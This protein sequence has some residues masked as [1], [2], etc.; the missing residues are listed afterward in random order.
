[1]TKNVIGDWYCSV[2]LRNFKR[3][4][5]AGLHLAQM[6][7]CREQHG[8]IFQNRGNQKDKTE[9]YKAVEKPLV[10]E[11]KEKLD[12]GSEDAIKIES[13]HR[14]QKKSV[15]ERKA[16]NNTQKRRSTRLGKRNWSPGYI[17]RV[18]DWCREQLSDEKA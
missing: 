15:S 1:M 14:A 10:G 3:A 9:E 5:N 18:I 7:S 12:S 13:E 8:M 2:C 16:V 4:C 11:E 6:P 17:V